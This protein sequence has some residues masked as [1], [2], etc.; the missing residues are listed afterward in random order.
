MMYG[1]D[2]ARD[3]RAHLL[4]A[5]PL[6]TDPRLFAASVGLIALFDPTADQLATVPKQLALTGLPEGVR[7]ATLVA[8]TLNA[9]GPG[10][11]YSAPAQRVLGVGGSIGRVIDPL[12]GLREAITVAR[13][14]RD[15]CCEAIDE[16]F[17]YGETAVGGYIGLL[18]EL[19]ELGVAA[20]PDVVDRWA[21]AYERLLEG[22]TP[23]EFLS[24]WS[25]TLRAS[26][27][28]IGTEPER[29]LLGRDPT[30]DLNRGKL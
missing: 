9:S 3:A 30:Y 8:A 27:K 16:G 19:R 24:E 15:R 26:F 18:V 29:K 13:S 2:D 21:T 11:P 4:A 14:I 10:L 17:V 22:E 7:E 23:D 12:L 6:P 1:S 28:L 20:N 5:L 25:R